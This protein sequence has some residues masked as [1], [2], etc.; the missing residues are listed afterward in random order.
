MHLGHALA[1][2]YQ[3]LSKFAAAFMALKNAKQA[4]YQQKPLDNKKSTL[5]FN[6]IKSLSQHHT[7]E[8]TVKH[9][10]DN[11]EPIFVLGM[12]RSGT[13][14]VER[15]LSSHSEVLSAG[16]LQD[17]G[18]AV[19]KLSQTNTMEVL[20]NQTIE[21]IYSKDFCALGRHYIDS[22]RVV[23]GTKKHFI[24]KLPFNFYYVDLIRKA[25]PNAKIICLLRNP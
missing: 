19:K 9:G 10:H 7:N 17:F 2:E 3:D 24:D 11:Q 5:L 14:L 12:P 6:T 15:I 1:K 20:D 21:A 25:L 16:E 13:T 4:K 23:T 22:T 18:I 8:Q